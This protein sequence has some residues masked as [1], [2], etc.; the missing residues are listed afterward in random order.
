VFAAT[1]HRVELILLLLLLL[2]AALTTLARR[3]QTPYPI[4]LVIAGLLLSFVPGLPRVTLNPQVVLLILLPPLLFSAATNTAWRDFR[5]HLVSIL[6]LAFGLVGFTVVGLSAASNWLLPGFD[7]NTG[8]VLGAVLCTTDAIAATAIATRVGLPRRIIDVL[9][10]ESLV[11][12]ASG[13]LALEFAVALVMTGAHPTVFAGLLQILYLLGAGIAVG[14]AVGWLAQ[15]AQKHVSDP[16]VEIT[17][18]L[19]VPY[20][21]Y[22]VAEQLR[23]SGAL[24]VV[25]CGLYLGRRNSEVYTSQ[26]RLEGIGVW[27]TLDFILNGT[28]FIVI[29]LQLRF[30]LAEIRT[31]SHAQ[32]IRDAAIVSGVTIALRLAWIYPGAAIAYFIRRHLLH[33]NVSIPKPKAVF[34][35]GWTGM[36]GVLA[37]A[38]AIS[39]P[40][41]LNN[42]TPFP[43]RNIIIFL[44]F[45]VILVTL[46]LQGLTL[47][48]LIRR[49]GLA[50]TEVRAAEEQDARRAMITA[51]LD[52][53]EKLGGQQTAELQSARADVSRHYQ[54][55]LS[56]ITSIEDKSRQDKELTRELKHSR[57]LTQELRGIER[58]TLQQLYADD[59]INDSVLRKL[60]REL[61]L[62]DARFASMP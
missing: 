20:L 4:V 38:A 2:A 9:E 22:L 46:V 55:R 24:A 28:V 32:L 36:R 35:L 61:D 17:I 59:K 27:N 10:G 18:S 37:L 5:F 48:T 30:I 33:Q 53:L 34:I 45:C 21:A 44:T 29:G 25:V 1:I 3:F 40:R 60:E 23:A 26:A 6:M 14:F 49:L 16:P 11:N 8:L 19:V 42:G 7:R 41:F 52:H 15:L 54:Q 56:N 57:R 58:E 43:Q 51:A 39:L 13:L 12:D 47:P 50:E 62:L 31:V